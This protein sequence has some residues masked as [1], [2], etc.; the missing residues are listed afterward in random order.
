M[1][2]H[3]PTAFTLIE[4]LVVIAIIAILAA[5]LFPVFARAKAAAQKTQS[6]SNAKQS[7]TSLILYTADY[8]DQ[9]SGGQTPNFVTGGYR[10]IQPSAV[11]ADGLVADGY[12]P[13]EEALAW[14]NA[15]QPYR[16]NYNV[17][18]FPG[19]PEVILS[20]AT[21]NLRALPEVT[22]TYNGALQHLPQTSV[23]SPSTYV[24]MWP[25][26]GAVRYRG[27]AY[28]NPYVF[29]TSR[30]CSFPNGHLIAVVFRE[31]QDTLTP[32][33]SQW[34]YGEGMTVVRADSSTRY[35]M[36]GGE[37]QRPDRELTEPFVNYR[38]QGRPWGTFYSLQNGFLLPRF[39]DPFRQP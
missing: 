39:W 33:R 24:M 20:G 9:F 13:N 23:A 37:G 10:D 14:P 19:T 18:S 3:S 31:Q 2:R 38:S 28:T 11:P 17:L 35:M 1:K 25:G 22:L 26:A 36:W 21:S 15:T 30:P 32:G 5:I 8:D 4:L 6:I 27:V 16:K 12:D 29:C 7:G 34:A